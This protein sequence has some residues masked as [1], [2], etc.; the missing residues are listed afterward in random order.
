MSSRNFIYLALWLGIF[1]L[2]A[3]VFVMI[4]KRAVFFRGLR[5]SP[6]LVLISG[7]LLFAGY[8]VFGGTSFG[9]CRYHAPVIPLIYIGIA[10]A[11]AKTDFEGL[12]SRRTQIFLAIS[13]FILVFI[14][15]DLLY[16]FRYT[17]R[18]Y[19]A[20][21]YASFLAEM[22]SASARIAIR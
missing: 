22:R 5:I 16:V 7:I 19:Q 1:F 14:V 20:F 12:G 15:R 11:A 4:K 8:S 9:Y 6:H 2:P 13:V 17:L 21:G 3:A 18:E 10:L